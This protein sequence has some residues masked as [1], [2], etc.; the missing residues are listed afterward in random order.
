[1]E[2]LGIEL[3]RSREQQCLTLTQVAEATRISLRHLQNLED[4]RYADLP[5]GM[6]NRAFLRSYC[7]YLGLDSKEMLQR[8]D[9]E[10]T[11][12]SEK[13]SKARAHL[14]QPRRESASRPLLV[15]VALLAVSITGLFL[16]RERLAAIFRPYFA[17]RPIVRVQDIASQ[18]GAQHG[19][20]PLPAP[21]NLPF[22]ESATPAVTAA[23]HE[24]ALPIAETPPKTP[25]PAPDLTL[26]DKIRLQF[27]IVQKCWVSVNSDGSPVL[28]R[29]LEPG[30]EQ[31]FNA[32][33]R[34]YI[35]LGNAGGVKLKINGKVAKQ[36]GSRGEV[37][38]VLINRQNI[39]DFVEKSAG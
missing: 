14:A 3:R 25:E 15:W 10:T 2:P 7:E 27:E 1:M 26:P 19:L 30:D 38:R 39:Q 23:T 24:P 36:L 21:A 29:L 33:D 37:V 20:P 35:I 11:P 22:R 5:G 9:A 8:Y 16:T 12:Q 34:F 32:N 18:S 31:F 6:Y 13:I 17:R 28:V 4:A